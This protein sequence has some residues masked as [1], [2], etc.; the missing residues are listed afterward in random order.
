MTEELS[1]FLISVIF[2]AVEVSV[3][4]SLS[5]KLRL[6]ID[7]IV[8]DFNKTLRMCQANI[9]DNSFFIPKK[10]EFLRYVDLR[11]LISGEFASVHNLCIS[12][13]QDKASS[14]IHEL[15]SLKAQ[16]VT[17]KDSEGID[18]LIAKLGDAP[19]SIFF[20]EVQED[21]IATGDLIGKIIHTE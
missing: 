8:F 6:Q 1:P 5:S 21:H 11:V 14:I 3:P 16:S 17:K 18:S 13:I 7:S 12:V 2:I 10:Y 20:V 4:P 19:E 15:S 9:E